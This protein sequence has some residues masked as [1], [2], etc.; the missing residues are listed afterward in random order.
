MHNLLLM[1][2]VQIELVDPKV[3]GS[4]RSKHFRTNVQRPKSDLIFSFCHDRTILI[5]EY[6]SF[7]GN[8]G[9]D[10]A[11]HSSCILMEPSLRGYGLFAFRRPHGLTHY[12][13]P[14]RF[15]LH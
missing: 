10:F 6:V 3:W 2:F 13:E 12:R 11:V 8:L 7:E 1:T 5:N 15:K 4:L 9:E 14:M